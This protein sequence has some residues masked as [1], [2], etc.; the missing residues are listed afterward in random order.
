[1]ILLSL[2]FHNFNFIVSPFN[3]TVIINRK[4]NLEKGTKIVDKSKGHLRARVPCVKKRS[5]VKTSMSTTAF[6]LLL[7]GW[8]IKV[9]D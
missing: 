2:I 4:L 9:V 8:S 5:G 6:R 3:D 7:D 1:M